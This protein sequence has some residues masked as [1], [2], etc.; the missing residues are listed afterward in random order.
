MI[1]LFFFLLF[2]LPFLLKFIRIKI[3][4]KGLEQPDMFICQLYQL[5][6][7]SE[8]HLFIFMMCSEELE[9]MFFSSIYSIVLSGQ[10]YICLNNDR[11][12]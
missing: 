4:C 8:M 6:N 11:R 12:I 10:F 9:S 7:L 1:Y 3:T 5:W 2:P